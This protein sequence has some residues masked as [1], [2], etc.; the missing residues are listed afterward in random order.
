MQRQDL[1]QTRDI[2]EIVKA[3]FVG[4]PIVC[5]AYSGFDASTKVFEC[6]DDLLSHLSGQRAQGVGHHMFT[7]RYPA[8]G[9]DVQTR[10]IA[11]RPEKCRGATWREQTAGW[12]L[13]TLEFSDVTESETTCAV[14]VNSAKRALAWAGTYPEL[15]DP[16]RWDW[17]AVE[18][19]ARRIIRVLRRVALG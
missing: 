3:A 9:G 7:L 14:S 5:E 6:A 18:R 19:E 11:L 17:Q 15:G 16:M 12:G 2:P 10:R 8:F 4:S 1:I 13:I